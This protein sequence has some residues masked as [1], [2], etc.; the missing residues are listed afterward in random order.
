[1]AVPDFY[2]KT[3]CSPEKAKSIAFVGHNRKDDGVVV[4]SVDELEKMLGY[5]LWHSE[6]CNTSEKDLDFWWNEEELV[7]VFSS[8]CF[9]Y[10]RFFFTQKTRL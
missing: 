9:L 3:F 6:K 10:A 4:H 7:R 8:V 2:F 1:M 5:K